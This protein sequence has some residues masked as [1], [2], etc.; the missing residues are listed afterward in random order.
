MMTGGIKQKPP[1][2]PF[3]LFGMRSNKPTSAP[4]A[5]HS[6]SK[7]LLDSVPSNKGNALNGIFT[8]WQKR[9]KPNSN[10][11][12]PVNPPTEPSIESINHSE[13]LAMTEDPE[14]PAPKKPATFSFGSASKS[15]DSDHESFITI[16]SPKPTPSVASETDI[17]VPASVVREDKD[18]NPAPSS[19]NPDLAHTTSTPPTSPTPVSVNTTPQSHKRDSDINSSDTDSDAPLYEE[20][21]LVDNQPYPSMM[22]AAPMETVFE[23]DEE[24]TR[25]ST[26]LTSEDGRHLSTTSDQ[27]RGVNAT[28]EAVAVGNAA[29]ANTATIEPAAIDAEMDMAVQPD[30]V[31]EPVS[32]VNSLDRVDQQTD[33]SFEMED[34]PSVTPAIHESTATLNDD[35]D[36][37]TKPIGQLMAETNPTDEIETVQP[38]PKLH[39]VLGQEYRENDAVRSKPK[40]L[41]VFGTEIREN[42]TLQSTPKLQRILG[43]IG[44]LATKK[45]DQSKKVWWKKLWA[46]LK[47]LFKRKSNMD[48]LQTVPSNPLEVLP[49]SSDSEGN[50]SAFQLVHYH[51]ELHEHPSKN[52]FNSAQ[53]TRDIPSAASEAD[54]SFDSIKK[55]SEDFEE[56]VPEK[57]TS[58]EDPTPSS[59]PINRVKKIRN[60]K[61]LAGILLP[62]ERLGS[63]NSVTKELVRVESIKIEHHLPDEPPSLPTLNF[64][65]VGKS[66][67]PPSAPES[68]NPPLDLIPTYNPPD[69]SAPET[70]TPS[71]APS[72]MFV[73]ENLARL[74]QEIMSSKSFAEI[75]RSNSLDPEEVMST[76][77]RNGSIRHEDK[78]D[79]LSFVE[80]ILTA[81]SKS[82]F[83]ASINEPASYSRAPAVITL[84]WARQGLLGQTPAMMMLGES[85]K[86]VPAKEVDED[87]VS[88]ISADLD[89]NVKAAL[90]YVD[91]SLL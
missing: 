85:G 49:P 39:R 48:E 22:I 70:E 32:T 40:L 28:I 9:L 27:V 8:S 76:L 75:A 57:S 84:P 87:L 30:T 56:N 35:D 15:D 10:T 47:A 31:A 61:S 91:D 2:A 67:I 1:K 53:Q 11:S 63:K 5:M 36:D 65:S 59:P 3:S 72:K 88:V 62:M 42:D 86:Y 77:M 33:Y 55:L 18:P 74:Y 60:R 78:A 51:D 64:N 17:I 21:I 73:N 26:I 81:R 6:S 66:F 79:T 24:R 12:P 29:A 25:A 90:A 37:D 68:D 54:K 45:A 46:K 43:A 71:D 23:E 58:I 82:L 20:P 44:P 34:R 83:P 52:N 38:V 80:S 50:G 7:N 14:P 19:D 16:E 13:A 41:K 4:D 69:F 89:A